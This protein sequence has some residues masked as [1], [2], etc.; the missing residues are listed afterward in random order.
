LELPYERDTL[1]G[2]GY[3]YYPSGILKEEFFYS[4]GKLD[5]TLR[6]YG[7]D[8]R[9]T[10]ISRLEE[11]SLIQ[12]TSINQLDENGR[13]QGFWEIKDKEGNLLEEGKYKDGKRNGS[14]RKYDKYG[15]V[16]HLEEY[17]NG[18]RIKQQEFSSLRFEEKY[19]EESGLWSRGPEKNGVKIGTHHFFDSTGNVLFSEVYR[20]DTLA[21]RG[22]VSDAG[23]K[24]SMWLYFF[25]NGQKSSEGSYQQGQ[26]TGK[27]IFYYPDGKKAQQGYYRENL[28]HGSWVWYYSNG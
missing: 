8:G 23:I 20:E 13:K 21:A 27:W 6:K 24:D 19:H 18:K 5:G 16:S 25:P 3:R 26:K 2:T 11:D 15:R 12:E 22:I 10:G 28:P 4:N 17:V 14:F 7:E 1:N 9:L